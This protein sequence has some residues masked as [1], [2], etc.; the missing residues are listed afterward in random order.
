MERLAEKLNKLFLFFLV[1]SI[2]FIL[3]FKTLPYT[4][5]FVVAIIFA[6]LLQKPTLLLVEKF[7]FTHS[8]ASLIT[9]FIFFSLIIILFTVS[10]TSIS[11]EIYQLT[12]TLSE[13]FSSSKQAPYVYFDNLVTTIQKYYN[14]LDPYIISSIQDSLNST[15]LKIANVTASTGVKVINTIFAFASSIPYILMVIVFTLIS[16]YF[17]TKDISTSGPSLLDRYAPTQTKKITYIFSE[18]KKML[19]S[20]LASYLLIILITFVTTLI[21]FLILRVKYALVLSLLCAIFDLLPVLGVATIYI[22]LAFIYLM[23]GLKFTGFGLIVLYGLVFFV[24]QITEPRIVSSS[25]GLHPVAVLAAIFIGLK[26]NGIAG[27]FF[28]MFL[29]VFYNIF[30]KVNIL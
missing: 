13:Y 10:I 24:R 29:V 5:P 16:T 6:L 19:L 22:P 7:K 27:M 23:S 11:S 4:L 18:S 21:G 8:I 9:T 20:Y 12:K 28:C 2:L 26:A 15:M 14:N 25:L 1:Y 17:F 30:K 3:F